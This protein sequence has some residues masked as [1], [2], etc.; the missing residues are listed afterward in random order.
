MQLYIKSLQR[1]ASPACVLQVHCSQQDD[2]ETG[3]I[4]TFLGNDSEEKLP[5]REV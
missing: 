3:R 2:S 5:A 4:F 1:Q